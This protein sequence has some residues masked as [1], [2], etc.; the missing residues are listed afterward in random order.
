MR[1]PTAQEL[2]EL[3]TIRNVVKP[4]DGHGEGTLSEDVIRVRARVQA[5]GGSMQGDTQ[6]QQISIQPYDI[7]IRYVRGLTAFMQ[8]EWNGK[9]L[10]ITGPPYDPWN[11]R[12]W[13]LINAEHTTEH[14]GS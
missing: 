9:I 10:V 11:T 3:I 7:A 2:T 1:E 13:L 4:F 12:R 5:Q 6:E 14:S 8:I